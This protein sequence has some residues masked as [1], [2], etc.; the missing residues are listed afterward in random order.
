MPQVDDVS[1][2]LE[3]I[4]AGLGVMTDRELVSTT[5]VTDLLLDVRALLSVSD[6]SGES[7][8]HAGQESGRKVLA[9]DPSTAPTTNPAA[10]SEP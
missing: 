5:E 7:T 2:A 4:D 8:E 6:R 3:I 9:N 10:T 1:A